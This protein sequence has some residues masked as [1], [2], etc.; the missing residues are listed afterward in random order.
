MLAVKNVL[1]NLGLVVVSILI[2]FFGIEFVLR[3]T[4]LQTTKPNPPLIFRQS[5]YPDI[6]YE[7][8]PNLKNEK[9]YRAA[10]STN[11]LG[12]RGPEPD[13]E[14]PIISL[15]GDSITFGYGVGDDETLAAYM[16]DLLPGYN[17]LNTAAPGYN[18]EQETGVLRRKIAPLDPDLIVLV[19]YLNDLEGEA[20]ILAQDGTLRPQGWTPKERDCNPITTGIMGLIPGRCWLDEHSA[21]YKAFRKV[22]DLRSSKQRKAVQQEESEEKPK[23]DTVTDEQLARYTQQLNGFIAHIDPGTPSVFVVWPDHLLHEPSRPRIRQIAEARGFQV[24]DLYDIFSNKVPTLPW[25]T[26][27]PNPNALKAAAQEITEFLINKK[28]VPGELSP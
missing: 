20:G 3:I 26:V 6:S 11:S 14:K 7:L 24:I 15:F 1:I 12:F 5:E 22:L 16:R 25:D 28:L 17:V 9:A 19:F 4:G 18:L 27:H 10:V 21:F 8:I 2:F 23:E 13:L